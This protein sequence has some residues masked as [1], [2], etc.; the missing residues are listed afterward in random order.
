MSN[1]I[2]ST[3]QEEVEKLQALGERKQNFR[4]PH[5]LREDLS[6]SS[7]LLY[8]EIKAESLH[9]LPTAPRPILLTARLH[10]IIICLKKAQKYLAELHS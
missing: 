5:T 8:K 4:D 7:L 3:Y 9:S 2:A 6:L 1:S 10:S